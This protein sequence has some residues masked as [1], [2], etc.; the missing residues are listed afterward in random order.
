M[1]AP[2]SSTRRRRPCDAAGSSQHLR[3]QPAVDPGGRRITINP[4][5]SSR[6]SRRETATCIGSRSPR[7]SGQFALRDPVSSVRLPHPGNIGQRSV[8]D[9]SAFGSNCDQA[10]RTAG[11]AVARRRIVTVPPRHRAPHSIQL[12]KCTLHV[13]PGNVHR[14]AEER[15]VRPCQPP[16]RGARRSPAAAAMFDRWHVEAGAR[17]PTRC[18][19]RWSGQ[20]SPSRSGRRATHASAERLRVRSPAHRPR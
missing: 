18:E 8:T 9:W 14:A 11:D 7:I 3:D 6:A 15:V 4:L 2:T 16:R 1:P 19:D 10:L 12:S 13:S 5:Q 17:P 20:R